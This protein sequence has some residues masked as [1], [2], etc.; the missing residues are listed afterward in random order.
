MSAPDLIADYYRRDLDADEEEALAAQLEASPEDAARFAQLAAAEYHSFGLPEP[1]GANAHKIPWKGL[2]AA[3]AVLLA[4]GFAYMAWPRHPR[5][6][7]IEQVDADYDMRDS[8]S[9][10][11]PPPR[12]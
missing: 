1:K 11:P 2:G 9:E 7:A 12:P 4:V 8:G 3:A 6:L 5:P 10:A